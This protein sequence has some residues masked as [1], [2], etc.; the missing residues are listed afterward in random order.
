VKGKTLVALGRRQQK[1]KK[2]TT[3]ATATIELRACCG[4]GEHWVLGK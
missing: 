3:A 1:K 4:V 2:T